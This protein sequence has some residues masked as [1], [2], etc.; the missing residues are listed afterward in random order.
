MAKMPTV[1]DAVRL[2]EG[3]LQKHGVQSPRLSAEHLLARALSCSR[4]DLYLRFE[5]GLAE[6]TLEKYR[7]DLKK[8]ASHCP[9]QYITGETEFYSLPFRVR[10][11]VFIPRPETE[12]LVES[13]DKSLGLPE[14]ARFLELG[15]GSG[16]IPATLASRNPGWTG[17]TFDINMG[18]AVLAKQNLATLGVDDR[19]SVFVGDRFEAIFD[20]VSFD[21][22][23][24]NPP[25]IPSGEI[26]GLQK[27]VSGWEPGSALD[28][29]AGGLDFY[30]G[31]ARAGM[32]LL[33]AGGAVALEIGAAQGR[34]VSEILAKEGYEDI[35]VTQDYNGL[36]RVVTALTP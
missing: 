19:V 26:E 15:C 6:E 22:L 5:E 11:G 33:V 20:S 13:I 31:L 29:G 32:K 34:D 14:N 17:V 3:Y 10:E 8:R 28:G 4:L 9:L 16:I 24:S 2:S 35:K 12:I 7:A 36:D 18:A 30:P 23:V 27:E 21:L 1:M 25:Y